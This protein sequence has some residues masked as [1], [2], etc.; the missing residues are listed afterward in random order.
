MEKRGYIEEKTRRG[1]N[2]GK[3]E[4]RKREEGRKK[5]ERE[6]REERRRRDSPRE[7]ERKPVAS[8]HLFSRSAF[9]ITNQNAAGAWRQKEGRKVP[10]S[11]MPGE[12]WSERTGGGK[13]GKVFEFAHR[14]TRFRKGAR[15]AGKRRE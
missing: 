3:K 4:G 6:K 10:K 13:N 1:K 8:L 14:E 12:R 11:H 9:H 2:D 7:R 5:E 15:D